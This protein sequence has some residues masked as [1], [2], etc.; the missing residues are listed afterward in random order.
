MLQKL[1]ASTMMA[2]TDI[3]ESVLSSIQNDMGYPG[4]ENCTIYDS[5]NFDGLYLNFGLNGEKNR[6]FDTSQY[7]MNDKTV[8]YWCGKNV[9]YRLCYDGVDDDCSHGHGESGAG[10]SKSN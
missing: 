2:F 5:V 3:K 10:T 7:N 9:L 1:T 4:D 6:N 8:S